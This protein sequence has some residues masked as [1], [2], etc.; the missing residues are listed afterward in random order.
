MAA[1]GKENNKYQGSKWISREKRLAIYMRDGLACAYC[2][3]SIEEGAHLSLD[4]LTPYCKAGDHRTQNL[5][6]ACVKCNSSRGNRSIGQFAEIV[7]A[8]LNRGVT[9]GDL[10]AH[11]GDCIAK[12]I[13]I[14]AVKEIIAT[15]GSWAAVLQN[16]R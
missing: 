3:D 4:H 12:P 1:R 11:I 13:D 2:G 7:A 10:M 6:T 14:K 5:V 16:E 8:Y 9:A 15:R